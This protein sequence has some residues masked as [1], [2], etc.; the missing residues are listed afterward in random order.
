MCAALFLN[1]HGS[2]GLSAPLQRARSPENLQ[3]SGCYHRVDR[4]MILFT[5]RHFQRDYSCRVHGTLSVS[6]WLLWQARAPHP[7]VSHLLRLLV[8]QTCLCLSYHMAPTAVN[9]SLVSYLYRF[10]VHVMYFPRSRKNPPPPSRESRWDPPVIFG[11]PE[12][13]A[14]GGALAT[15]QLQFCSKHGFGSHISPPGQRRRLHCFGNTFF[16]KKMTADGPKCMDSTPKCVAPPP[17][18]RFLTSKHPAYS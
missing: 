17:P 13:A 6:H 1:F 7:G 11:Q 8:M 12:R 18:R 2:Q 15:Y 10:T 16:C 4:N 14:A 5:Y 9:I 3:H